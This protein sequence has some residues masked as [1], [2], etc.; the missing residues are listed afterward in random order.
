MFRSLPSKLNLQDTRGLSRAFGVLGRKDSP[1]GDAAKSLKVELLRVDL[2]IVGSKCC[3]V[4]SF[5]GLIVQLSHSS[6]DISSFSLNAFVDPKVYEDAQEDWAKQ[7]P[8][9]EKYGWG[10]SVHAEKWN[11]RHAMFGWLFI[12]ASA[13]CKGHGL[14][15]DAETTLN[16]KEWGTLATISGKETISMERAIVLAAN[17]H[18]FGVSLMATMCPPSWGDSLLLDPNHPNYEAM[19][20]RNKNGFGY[21][22]EFKAGITEEAEVIN[23]R[24]ASE[25]PLVRLAALRY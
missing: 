16:L 11:G 14:I 2:G 15:P 24:L 6:T 17:A 4:R 5:C 22:P 8:Q 18:F 20:E 3:S 1:F 23:G 25:Y 12:C 19:A 10:P 9:F 7:Y 13:Y 21:L